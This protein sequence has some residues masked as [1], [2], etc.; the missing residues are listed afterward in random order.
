MAP[1]PCPTY[2]TTPSYSQTARSLALSQ[3]PSPSRTPP[4]QPRP[5][6]ARSG[7]INSSTI[8]WSRHRR[9]SHSTL[10]IHRRA[11]R[12]TDKYLRRSMRMYK[13]LSLVQKVALS[14]FGLVSLVGSIL[15]FVYSEQVF[16]WLRPIADK[17][18]DMTAGWVLLWVATFLT[19][20][21]P[22][23]G[24]STCVTLAGFVFGMK[25]WFII[26]TANV[27]GSLCSFLLFKYLLSGFAERLA[28]KDPRFAAFGL[29]IEHDGLGIL[30]LIRLTP[31]PYSLS[32]GGLS[33][34]RT[35]KPWA[36]AAATAMATPKLLIHVFIG[37]RLR[38]IAGGN[39]DTQ[40]KLI[41]WASII[42]GM[43]LGA[44]TGFIIYRRT[45]ARAKVLEAEERRKQA[46]D[47]TRSGRLEHPDVFEDD[48]DD[49]DLHV[50]EDVID[51]I[52]GRYDDDEEHGGGVGRYADDD[53]FDAAVD[54]EGGIG[55]TR[56]KH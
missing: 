33:T 16:G 39:L 10:P 44:V 4:P 43:V 35:I 37:T 17:W 51:F 27:I 5:Q 20:F 14:S 32:N 22:L 40:T 48:E 11:L 45:V 8:L 42:F 56:T 29:V 18:K 21:P 1:S 23:I 28:A 52:D 9:P 30:V 47:S 41:N 6:W 13:Q 55:M 2:N 53:D 50:A 38:E 15:V 24:Y 12:K 49:E 34:V 46:A 7:S 3:S 54:G 36:F 31:L 19:A 26:A 25:G